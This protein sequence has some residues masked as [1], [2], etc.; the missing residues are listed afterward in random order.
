MELGPQRREVERVARDGDLGEAL[1]ERGDAVLAGAVERDRGVRAIAED[2]AHHRGE[3]AA[4]P[5]L[6]EGAGA[7]GVHRLDHLDE[8]HALGDRGPELGAD[9]R[10]L[11]GVGLGRGV[12]V[13]RERRALEHDAF[14]APG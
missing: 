1:P 12:A 10:G 11:G 14:E 9:G 13:D 7:A 5:D 6:D 8:A 4:R 2:A 3:H